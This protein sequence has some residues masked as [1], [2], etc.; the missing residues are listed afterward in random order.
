MYRGRKSRIDQKKNID[1]IRRH[2]FLITFLF[3]SVLG[4]KNDINV[5]FLIVTYAT[6]K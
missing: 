4:R 6:K 3:L 5:K 2:K 1:G